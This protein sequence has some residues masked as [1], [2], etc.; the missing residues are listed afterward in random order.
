MHTWYTRGYLSFAYD[1]IYSNTAMTVFDDPKYP[2]FMLN[3]HATG[4]LAPVTA[5][6]GCVLA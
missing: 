5:Q 6:T 2:Q 4:E 1:F 3:D